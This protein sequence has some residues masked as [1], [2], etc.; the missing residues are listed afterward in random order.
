MDIYSIGEMVIDFIPGQG[1]GEYIRNAGGAPANVAIA[2]AH[3]G[4][5]AGMCCKVGDDDFGR[6]LIS[7]LKNEKVEVLCEELCGEA[8]TTMA[9][10][11]LKEGGE[12]SFTFARKPGADMFLRKEDVKEADIERTTV[13]HAGS[14]SLS[15]ET[16]ASATKR[17]MEL[18]HG[19]GKIVSFDINYRD[20][21]WNGEK[22][23]C[24]AAVSEL[25]PLIDLL[26]VSEEEID[27]VGGE[28]SLAKLVAEGKLAVAIETLGSKG[29]KLFF[30]GKVLSVEGIKAKA[31]DATGAGDA[32]WGGFLSSLLIQGVKNVSDI[33]EAKLLYAMKYGNVSGALCVQKKG[34]IASLPT[35]KEIETILENESHE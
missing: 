27:M 5:E 14:C 2:V 9:F 33:D 10:V 21:M 19:L 6:F 7:T 8:T 11:S 4:L 15:A 23:K 13:V 17:A 35:R 3:N 30:G 20:L 18:A 31:I 28:E 16:V 26:K 29:A 22:S 34:A 25:L 24:A 32:F 12:R 1:E